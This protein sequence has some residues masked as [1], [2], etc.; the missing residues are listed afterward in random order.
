MKDKVAVVTG[1]GT[2]IGQGIALE[3]GKRGAVVLVHYHSSEAGAEETV[4]S[5]T[6]AGGRARAVQADL[7]QVSECQRLIGSCLDTFG[8]I[9][10]LVNNSGV[11]TKADFVEV[12]EELWDLTVDI[13]LKASFFCAQA[14]V[15]QMI[16][17]GG[18]GKIVHIGS[19]HGNL[20]LPG[21][22]P[23]AAAKGGLHNLTRQ[24][25]YELAPH[26]INVNCIAPGVI[27]VERYY[28]F[29][30]DYDR[31]KWARTVPWGRVGFPRDI[32]GVVAFLC[33]DDA[34]FVTGQVICVDGGQTSSLKFEP[35]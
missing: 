29:E 10:I 28:T 12:T 14:A 4:R 20:S 34:D 22:G 26:R 32:A 24:M 23:Y 17:Q 1:A 25:A 16:A 18:G 33:S 6:G 8:R 5:I 15:R 31:A 2:G 7:S 30:A 13:S 27:E 35:D 21:F 11:T 19:V 3:L 9:D